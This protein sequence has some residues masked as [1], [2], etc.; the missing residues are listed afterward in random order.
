MINW[1]ALIDRPYA[2]GFAISKP[3]GIQSNAF[4]KSIATV[5]LQSFLRQG[6][7]ASI[8]LIVK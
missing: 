5:P 7:D 1:Q 3:C 8:P 6:L 4:D 2:W